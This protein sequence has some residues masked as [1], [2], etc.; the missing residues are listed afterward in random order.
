[1]D[2][3]VRVA[4]VP[5]TIDVGLTEIMT[6]GGGLVTVR[7]AEALALPPAPVHVRV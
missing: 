3:Q 5:N 7:A 4:F 2:D 6:V 1:V